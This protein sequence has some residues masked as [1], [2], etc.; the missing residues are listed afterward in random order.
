MVRRLT[1]R[2]QVKNRS[3][4]S[5]NN[6][7]RKTRRGKYIKKRR[8]VTR[9]RV[10]RGGD[11]DV[12][13]IINAIKSKSPERFKLLVTGLENAP[14]ILIQHRL[15][16]AY[17]EM[18][19]LRKDG[20][21]T[22]YIGLTGLKFLNYLWARV[23]LLVKSGD[24]C[25]QTKYENLQKAISY[26]DQ[27]ALAPGIKNEQLPTIRKLSPDPYYYN[28]YEKLFKELSV[29]MSVASRDIPL[30]T[31]ACHLNDNCGKDD[32]DSCDSNGECCIP[33]GL[34]PGLPID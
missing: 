3:K 25:V 7:Y 33:N 34:P 24:P 4:H 19:E 8:S 23:K 17:K 32:N 31:S 18:I 16:I 12:Q 2:R 9:R 21:P 5:R 26:M 30:S 20:A 29:L 1:R 22:G 13:A 11:V 15:Q 27:F 6:K 28:C 10:L 14:G